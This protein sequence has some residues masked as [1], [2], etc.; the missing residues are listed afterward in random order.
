MDSIFASLIVLARKAERNNKKL[1]IGL[2]TNWIPGYGEK[3]SLQNSA[4]SPLVRGVSTLK[5]ELASMGI[6]NVDFIS[7]KGGELASEI[8]KKAEEEDLADVVVLA[9]EETIALKDFDSLR[10]TS[11]A[12][13]AFLASVDHT[14]LEKAYNEHGEEYDKQLMIQ[15]VEMLS[16]TLQLASS[17]GSRGNLPS[18]VRSYDKDSR[19]LHFL[20]RPEPMEYKLLQQTY[21]AKLKA[22]HSV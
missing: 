12:R 2:E 19:T 6:T 11:G 7:G 22:L 1:M 14:E 16:I 10:S 5:K 13:R 20:P 15:L 18:I 4:I 3:G 17:E 21:K 8:L 9:S